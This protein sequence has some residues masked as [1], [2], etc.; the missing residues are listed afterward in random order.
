MK[1]AASRYTEVKLDP[2][3]NEIFRGIDKD[4]VDLIDNYDGTMKEPTLLPTAFPN[5]LVT[6]NMGIAVG[7]AS[8]VC[9]FNLTEVCDGTIAL[10]KNP[11]QSKL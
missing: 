9:P 2:F 10:L 7:I 5:L 3:C 4:A 6:P 11:K 8:S 1:Y